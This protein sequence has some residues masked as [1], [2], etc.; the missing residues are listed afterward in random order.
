MRHFQDTK[1]ISNNINKIFRPGRRI[2]QP[3]SI[4]FENA[5]SADIS[6]RPQNE[7]YN[8]DLYS[9]PAW[10]AGMRDRVW[11]QAKDTRGRVRDPLTGRYM[12]KDK[13]WDI[14]RSHRGE[15]RTEDYFAAAT[16]EVAKDVATSVAIEVVAKPL[17]SKIVS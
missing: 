1:N 3:K 6:R 17:I 15:S 12:S 10:R 2:E 16:K 13:A 7:I 11:E 4:Y 14:Y 8:G 5:K 9:R